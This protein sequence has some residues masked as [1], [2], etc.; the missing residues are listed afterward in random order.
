MDDVINGGHPFTLASSGLTRRALRHRLASGA[1][2]AVLPG[3]YL[4]AGVP[5]TVALRAQALQL[6]VP[7]HAVVCRATASWLYEVPGPFLGADAWTP[8]LDLAVVEGAAALRRP[9]V[10]S[11][12]EHLAPEDICLVDGIRVTTPL[13]TAADLGRWLGR[14]DAIGSL[15]AFLR[16]GLVGREQLVAEA[17]RWFGFR[18]VKQ[19]RELVRFADP[20]AE[21]HRESWLRLLLHDAGFPPVELQ[22]PVERGPGTEPYRLDLAIPSLRT[23]FEY[24]GADSHGPEQTAHDDERRRFIR[25]LGWTL[26]VV[27]R[28]DLERPQRL[29]DAVGMFVSP[30]RPPRRELGVRTGLGAAV[31]RVS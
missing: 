16:S 8:T 30:I 22:W 19:L 7:P 20:M 21:S 10:N 28:G 11:F 13:R 26:L 12:V 18:Y 23:A 3:A 9:H 4:A 5:L 17:D 2:R 31:E 1:I 15:D 29:V 25:G 6:V 14:Y 27:R 24:D